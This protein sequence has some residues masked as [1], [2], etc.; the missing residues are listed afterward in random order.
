MKN[1]RNERK[2]PTDA[3]THTFTAPLS[4]PATQKPEVNASAFADLPNTR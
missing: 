4:R 1:R 3:G 2:N